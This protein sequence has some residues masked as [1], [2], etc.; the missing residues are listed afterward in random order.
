MRKKG[1][2]VTEEEAREDDIVRKI[3]TTGVQATATG[4]TMEETSET[5]DDGVMEVDE[6]D[7]AGTLTMKK[8]DATIPPATDEGSKKLKRV[9]HDTPK[10]IRTANAKPPAR[11]S[12][13]YTRPDDDN[14]TNF[15]EFPEEQPGVLSIR[16][17]FMTSSS[18]GIQRFGSSAAR[19]GR[20]QQSGGRFNSS[21]QLTRS[22]TVLT[23]KTGRYFDS[24]DDD[25]EFRPPKSKKVIPISRPSTPQV[26]IPHMDTRKT[27]MSN[28][29]PEGSM[30]KGIRKVNPALH[31]HMDMMEEKR[32]G[33][34]F[35][36]RYLIIYA[37]AGYAIGLYRKE[38]NPQLEA[39]QHAVPLLMQFGFKE[40]TDR[41]FRC[42]VGE[43]QIV[44]AYR[45][46]MDPKTGRR[47]PLQDTR[48]NIRRYLGEDGRPVPYTVATKSA[49]GQNSPYSVVA[50]LGIVDT[51]SKTDDNGVEE[52]KVNVCSAD[53]IL[54]IE[55]NNSQVSYMFLM[56]PAH[57]E[58]VTLDGMYI[59]KVGLYWKKYGCMF[60]Y[61]Y[62][63]DMEAV[64]QG[65]YLSRLATNVHEKILDDIKPGWMEFD[66]KRFY[67]KLRVE[68]QIGG[69]TMVFEA[70][71]DRRNKAM[72][73]T[74]V[75]KVDIF[76][77]FVYTVHINTEGMI[78]DQ[79]DAV[80]HM[81]R[82]WNVELVRKG[83]KDG[84]WNKGDI[85][86]M[87][88]TIEKIHYR[89]K[90]PISMEIKMIPGTTNHQVDIDS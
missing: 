40:L 24:V 5:D 14:A 18:G 54:P 41:E 36:I 58:I 51:S 89:D 74:P 34:K 1:G 73:T 56:I 80:C 71:M 53:D 55:A 4:D 33:Q 11:V 83:Y 15:D 50:S 2:I 70:M 64:K 47:L 86:V 7:M 78:P 21:T 43:I 27:M 87:Q 10:I 82:N 90:V 13:S 3:L 79:L 26:D 57:A 8:T 23:G 16:N 85:H 68:T 19:P 59:P 62:E 35:G 77:D 61:E 30:F 65:F 12:E 88:G 25:M 6:G 9:I 67:D 76:D 42:Y 46:L 52:W 32:M 69:A 44:Q 20:Y 38:E 66:K 17:R 84:V 81:E 22:Q 28:G 72:A 60:P 29:M 37:E 75:S 49:C 31:R 45:Y 48:H 63:A 39:I